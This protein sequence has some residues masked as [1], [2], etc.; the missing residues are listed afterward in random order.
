MNQLS[1]SLVSSICP[2][3]IVD[4]LTCLTWLRPAIQDFLTIIFLVNLPRKLD[5]A[6]LIFQLIAFSRRRYIR[7]AFSS[8]RLFILVI[9]FHYHKPKY[10]HCH[11]AFKMPMQVPQKVIILYWHKMPRIRLQSCA[12]ERS[13]RRF[14]NDLH[15]VQTILLFPTIFHGHFPGLEFFIPFADSSEHDLEIRP[16]VAC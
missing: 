9:S 15:I 14:S 2:N 6:P 7:I 4:I 5:S 16:L 11:F 10:H 1:S 12:T 13:F 3:F 8:R